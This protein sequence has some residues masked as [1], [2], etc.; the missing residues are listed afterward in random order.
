MVTRNSYEWTRGKR[1]GA[2]V[3]KKG[4][5]HSIYVTLSEVDCGR[6]LLLAGQRM[7]VMTGYN[8]SNSHLHQPL[9]VEREGGGRVAYFTASTGKGWGNLFLHYNI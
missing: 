2:G 3:G 7:P 6:L 8:Y 1:M 9:L 4:T 5:K